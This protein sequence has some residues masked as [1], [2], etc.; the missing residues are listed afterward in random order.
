MN[1]PHCDASDENFAVSH[2][3]DGVAEYANYTCMYCGWEWED[4]S[5]IEWHFNNDE[6][7]DAG[8]A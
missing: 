8:M 7:L 6:L 4:A 2:T 1:C 5:I 3:Y